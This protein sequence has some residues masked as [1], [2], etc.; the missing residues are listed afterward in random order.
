MSRQSPNP[1]GEQDV[2]KQLD[3]WAAALEM[4]VAKLTETLIEVKAFQERKGTDDD[5]SDPSPDGG[6]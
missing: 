4:A 6:G 2:T 5:G 3:S 1:F